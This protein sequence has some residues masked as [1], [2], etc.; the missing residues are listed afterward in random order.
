MTLCPS[1]ANIDD[2]PAK[3]REASSSWG[4]H[5]RM[6]SF[7]ELLVVERIRIH[8]ARTS[9]SQ[10]Q[11]LYHPLADSTSTSSSISPSTALY[12]TIITPFSFSKFFSVLAVHNDPSTDYP[13]KAALRALQKTNADLRSPA[14]SSHLVVRVC[15]S[16]SPLSGES[17]HA[18]ST[19]RNPF[20]RRIARV[21]AHVPPVGALLH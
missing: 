20:Q 21:A 5:L 15:L 6:T 18:W 2:A 11:H 8:S 12:S 13:T 10:H 4:A 9:A 7:D 16:A 19:C 1:A 17:R 14:A 3:K